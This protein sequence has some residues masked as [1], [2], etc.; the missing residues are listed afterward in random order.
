[1]TDSLAS[2][3]CRI[4]VCR[5]NSL[6]VKVLATA[7]V[8][9]VVGRPAALISATLKCSPSEIRL[10]RP[11]SSQQLLVFQHSDQRG[12]DLTHQATYTVRD[13]SICQVTSRGLVTPRTDGQ[14]LVIIQCDGQSV[15]V[16]VKVDGYNRPPPIEFGR[17][18]IPI[19]AKAGCSSSGC[20]GKA[21]GQNGFLLSIF[22]SDP[23]LDFDALSKHGRARRIQLAAPE[24]SLLLRKATGELPHGGGQ[25]FESDGIWYRR[26]ARWIAEGAQWTET[27]DGQIVSIE[28]EPAQ[29][30]LSVRGTQQ[31]RVTA[32][33]RAGRRH[34]VTREADFQSNSKA[35]AVVDQNG[36][37]AVNEVA[38]A[39]AIL[40]RYMGHVTVC[41]VTL[42]QS[43]FV[44]ERPAE[45]NFIDTLVWKR[46]QEL[47]IPAGDRCDDA[48]Y[49]RRVYLDT[50]GT[51]PTVAEARAFL[52]D[53][54]PDK[55]GR[56]ADELLHRDEYADYWSMI[57]GDLFGADR[58]KLGGP[59]AVAMSRWLR[60]QFRQNRPYDQWVREV[61]T[62]KGD[63]TR[64]TPAG[65]F[66]VHN[67]TEEMSRAVSQIFLGVRIECAQ[68]HHHPFER[69]SQNDYY[70]LAGVFSG[71]K[72]KATPH[73]GKKIVGGTAS[74][75]NHPRTG[76]PVDIA[77]LGGEPLELT[78]DTR[79]ELAEWMTAADNPFVAK[80][81][82]NR[83]WA[84]YFGRGLVDPVDDMRSTNP[85]SNERLLDA[86]A[87]HFVKS[88][89]DIH[90]ITRVMLASQTY[91]RSFVTQ[92]GNEADTQNYSHATWKPLPAEVLLDAIC[93]ATGVAEQFNGWP[94][95]YRA[96]QL[97]DNRMPSYF[98]TVFGR[99]QRVSVC[100]CERGNQPS[101]AQ[102]L[103]LMNA[104]ETLSKLQNLDGRVAKLCKS[105][106][107]PTSIIQELYLATLS[108]YPTDEEIAWMMQAYGEGDDVRKSTEDVLWALLNTKEFLFNH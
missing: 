41:R 78:G 46:L 64:E 62:A 24:R 67:N 72:A 4:V 54:S 58:E 71:V 2:C 69:W 92:A 47:G 49:L 106:S 43:G 15:E 104:P 73:G 30:I 76:K 81:L 96:I 70:A 13:S 23:E 75:L 86:L 18:V 37:V 108:R 100:D 27:A 9:L 93:Q 6:S 77:P 97:W 105:L 7:V 80:A 66:L 12:A 82:V 101:V 88:G 25:R 91:Q 79:R 63:P 53:Q 17:E 44:M 11:E 55:R 83:L 68:C 95:G 29:A 26:V 57:W 89:F 34:C 21:E 48:M 90:E 61:V 19:L 22:G 40:V 33:D 42:P 85:A 28:V 20:H 39:A 94:V 38:G 36:R 50:I 103:H 3:E 32:I 87:D 60:T 102:A 98:F 45:S 5:V 74:P 99:P 56:L 59:G 107:E 31:L 8:M 84:H 14:T 51:L 16:P 35:I 1:M 65:F 10:D 52:A